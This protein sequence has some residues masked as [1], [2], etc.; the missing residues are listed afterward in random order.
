MATKKKAARAK[1]KRRTVRKAAMKKGLEELV[2]QCMSDARFVRDLQKNPEETL[3]KNGYPSDAKLV[4]AI[5]KIDFK[6]FRS[7]NTRLRA[8][9][10]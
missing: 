8:A 2:K 7:F 9:F 5:A 6:V 1:T 4:N 3:E 10:C